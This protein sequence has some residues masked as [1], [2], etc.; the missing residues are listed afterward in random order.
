MICSSSQHTHLFQV[1]C[2]LVF[3][4]TD[5]VFHESYYIKTSLHGLMYI[6]FDLYTCKI[7]IYIFDMK[8]KN[9]LNWKPNFRLVCVYELEH[10]NTIYLYT[11]SKLN[12]SRS[13]CKT[14]SPSRLDPNA[15]QWVWLQPSTRCDLDARALESISESSKS[16]VEANHLLISWSNIWN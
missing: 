11:R 4:L 14:P 10:I 8:S 7:Y 9:R 3:G 15:I 13:S 6:R 5:L 1:S 2:L 16:F 12:K